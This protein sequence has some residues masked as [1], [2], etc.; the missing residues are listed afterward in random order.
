MRYLV[1]FIATLIS[2]LAQGGM[3]RAA[4]IA[5][6]NLIGFSSDG[7]YFAFEE[8]G[9]Q[10]GSGFPYSN[11][12]V[13]N[14]AVDTFAE[15]TPVRVRIDAEVPLAGARKAAAAKVAPIFNNLGIGADPG[16]LLV[17]NPVTEQKS[18]PSKVSFYS[19]ASNMPFGNVNRL[20][21]SNVAVPMPDRCKDF[22]D[23]PVGFKLT[24]TT[25]AD[26]APTIVHEDKRLPDSRFCPTSY[27]IAAVVSAEAENVQRVAI[28]QYNYNSFEGTDGRFIAVPLN[29]SKTLQ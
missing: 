5:D 26:N 11:I 7:Q 23:V 28:I 3:T 18:D 6:L 2:V 20:E 24:A 27:R 21:I 22:G 15:G 1:G 8:F 13:I 9:I 29:L 17:F 14:L 10:D 4:D 12:F 16:H 25:G 19:Y